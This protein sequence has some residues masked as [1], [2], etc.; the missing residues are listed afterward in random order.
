MKIFIDTNIFID[1][2]QKREEIAAA[3]KIFSLIESGFFTA[4]IA[5]VTL[6]N[7]AYIARKQQVDI[8][9]FLY[10]VCKQCIV[11]GAGNSDAEAALALKNQDFE[12]NLQSILAH[13]ALCQMIITNDKTFP[14]DKIKVISS[15]EFVKHY[16]LS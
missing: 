12:D 9:K 6:V 13:K 8:T 16:C 14:Q 4:Y 15:S 2:V 10:Y 11:L 3:K 1:L 7:I 5:D